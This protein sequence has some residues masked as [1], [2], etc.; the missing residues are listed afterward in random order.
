MWFTGQFQLPDVLWNWDQMYGSLFGKQSISLTSTDLETNLKSKYSSKHPTIQLWFHEN[1]FYFGMTED[2]GEHRKSVR[3][4]NLPT[5]WLHIFPSILAFNEPTYNFSLLNRTRFTVHI[6]FYFSLSGE[7][8]FTCKHCK[9]SFSQ[10]SHCKQHKE[11]H[12]RASLLFSPNSTYFAHLAY[13][14]T[15]FDQSRRSENFQ[16]SGLCKSFLIYIFFLA[17]FQSWR[18]LVTPYKIYYAF[19][20]NMLF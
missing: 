8:P 14:M 10:S 3:L 2:T 9:K 7:K 19:K 5:Y 15:C 6:L 18:L 20:A 12:A 16:Q 11:R 4:S 17:I 1:G 13:H